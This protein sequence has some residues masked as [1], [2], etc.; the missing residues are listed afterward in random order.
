MRTLGEEH[1]LKNNILMGWDIL[2]LP[3]NRI[4]RKTGPDHVYSI[5][6]KKNEHKILNMIIVLNP[7]QTAIKYIGGREI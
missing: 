3:K 4:L 6:V 7:G 5:N 1:N 2:Y